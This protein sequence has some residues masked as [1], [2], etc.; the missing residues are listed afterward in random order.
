MLTLLIT[1]L[2]HLESFLDPVSARFPVAAL[3]MI[4]D[5]CTATLGKLVIVR[6]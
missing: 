5:A 3:T 4:L 2:G 6:L 1:Y